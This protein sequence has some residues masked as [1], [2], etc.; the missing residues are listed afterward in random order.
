MPFSRPAVRR[1][2]AAALAALLLL[3]SV[4]LHRSGTV[5]AFMPDFLAALF[6]AGSPGSSTH[7]SITLEVVRDYDRD[8]FG[9]AAKGELTERMEKAAEEISQK[10]ADVDDPFGVQFNRSAS[11]FDG[12]NF[13]GS[14]RRLKQY[15]ANVKLNMARKRVTRARFF[16]GQALHT[17]QDFYA[18]S[19]WVELGHT[20]L[21]TALGVSVPAANPPRTSKTCTDCTR[22]T[23]TDCYNPQAHLTNLTTSEVTTGYYGGDDRPKPRNNPFKCSHG[24]RVHVPVMGYRR[25]TS[26]KGELSNGINKDTRACETSPHHD[27][28]NRAATLAEQATKKYL[29]QVKELIGA[30]KMKVLLGGG[31]TLAMA[32]DTTGSMGSII[33]QV[34]QQ[35]IQ[36]INSRLGTDD[37]PTAYVLVPFNDPDVGPAT[38]TDDPDVFKNAISSLTASGGGDC[39]ER[40]MTGMLTALNNM[41]DGGDLLMFTDATSNDGSLAGAVDSVALSKKVKISPILFGSCSPIDP[42]YIRAAADSGGQLFFLSRNEAGNITRLADF[43]VRAN[44]VD[45]L[46]VS[47]TL[48]G[49]EKSFSVPVDS[50]MSRVTF[51]VSGTTNVSVKRPD[52]SVVRA[53]DADLTFVPL[54]SGAI[55]SVAGPATGTWTVTLGG[56][57]DFSLRTLGVSNL[58][59]T[60]FDFV[61][62][63]GRA[64]HEGFF[65]VGGLPPAGRPSQVWAAVTPQAADAHFDLRAVD[66][67]PLSS[68]AAQAVPWPSLQEDDQNPQPGVGPTKDFL[69]EGT[70]PDAPL[71]AYV[72]GLDAN[73]VPYQRVMPGVIK[74]QTVQVI[75]PQN[76]DLVAGRTTAY[77]VQ[78]KNLGAPGGIRLSASD[79][80]GYFAGLDRTFVDLGTNETA[81]VTVRLQPPAD[82]E[83]YTVD[84]LTITAQKSG[85]AGEGNFAVITSMVIPAP[86]V[87]LG[88]VTAAPSGGDG[89]AFIE[90]G[91][92]GSL[93]VQLSNVSGG[94]VTGVVASL[95]SL[96]PGVTVLSGESP[97]PDL[98]PGGGGSNGVPFTFQLGAGVRCGQVV[99]FEMQVDFEGEEEPALL[100]FSVPT[101][102]VSETAGTSVV[103]YNGPP[104]PI[105]DANPSGVSIP[106][107]VSGL[108]GAL[109]DLKFRFDGSSCSTDVGSTTVG[110]DHTFLSDLVITLTS[111]AGT[112]VTLVNEGGGSGNN[113]CQTLLEDQSG[114]FPLD[115]FGSGGAPFTGS[116]KPSRPLSAFQGENPNG[117]WVLNVSDHFFADVGSV[118]AFS[119]I[120]NAVDRTAECDARPAGADLVVSTAASPDPVLTGSEVTYT[121]T[122]TNNGP[123][124]AD[125]VTVTAALPDETTLVSCG[126]T[127]GGVCGVGAG[128]PT[129][130]FGSL[131]AGASATVTL[132]ANVNCA[133]PDG[134]SLNGGA[135]VGSATADPDLSNNKAS[136]T[137]RTSN[138][139]PSINDASADPPV[140]WPP[141]H[142]MV[143]VTVAYGVTDNCGPLAN[144]LGVSSSEPADGTGDGDTA[145]DWRVIDD[146]HVLLRAER[147]GGGAGRVYTITITSTDSAGYSSRRSVTVSVPHSR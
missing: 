78:V 147:A 135:T 130:S 22:D 55:F 124:D 122:V 61:E 121:T 39:P 75:R 139:A 29:D 81:D 26:G 41:E 83:P 11:H 106:V 30:P 105:P 102:Q 31:S 100:Y 23:C 34:K 27:L 86:A 28:H 116:F 111:P 48:S 46:T 65:P 97:Y 131:P 96:T 66:G 119:L 57:G 38:V 45:L 145:P 77:V 50:T 51:S 3:A 12:E 129:V 42:G 9:L 21:N 101:G 32:I 123:D 44:A 136:A 87:G 118:R 95:S 103:S 104:V 37:E 108:R 109:S 144:A 90:P 25:D 62:V 63:R 114:N 94:P 74:P 99:S 2:S 88:A 80:Q 128:G 110:L 143:P 140:L 117:T 14:Q 134:V 115:F 13:V 98:A 10:D 125:S 126:A 17:L 40:S 20:D 64:L 58:S 19:N 54:S 18:H 36:L 79:D 59:F 133:V 67:T 43:L 6:L 5:R 92:D 76:Q 107:T 132:V 24:G 53:T 85:A 4:P 73:G 47:G 82:A 112:T 72:T 138:P 49:A 15:L 7:Y 60:K 68:F 91:E 93:N 8:L 35:A 142:R 89:D 56:A 137:V 1:L 113:L 120:V 33:A 141:N 127:N 84:D 16:L 69:G 71:R 52:G 70:V 146:H